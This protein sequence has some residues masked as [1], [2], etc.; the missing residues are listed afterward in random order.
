M[1]TTAT[2]VAL[3]AR[4]RSNS[5]SISR[6]DSAAVGSSMTR[7]RAFCESAFAISTTCC[8][9]MPSSWTSVRV[10]R[11]RP[12]ASSSRRASACIRR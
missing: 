11:S 7:M 9:A 4:T 6:S 8:C 2:P 12:S 3:S 1:Y 10:S 5:R